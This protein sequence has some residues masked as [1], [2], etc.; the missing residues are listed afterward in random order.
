MVFEQG[1]F[2]NQKEV[3]GDEKNV[4]A[5]VERNAVAIKERLS[6]MT[7]T[8]LTAFFEAIMLCGWDASGEGGNGETSDE[9][10]FPQDERS[11]GSYG[12]TGLKFGENPLVVERMKK[13]LGL[14]K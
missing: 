9:K 7:P 4:S 14:E 1:G 2:G 8:E 12:A 13:L 6:A 10:R 3:V 11:D 5:F